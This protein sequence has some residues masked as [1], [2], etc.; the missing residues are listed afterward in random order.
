MVRRPRPRSET[1]VP[2][3]EK[4]LVNAGAIEQLGTPADLYF[5]PRTLFVADFLGESNLLSATVSEVSGQELGITLTDGR[6]ARRAVG[7]GSAFRPGQGVRIMVRPQNLTVRPASGQP[8]PLAGRLTRWPP[9][10]PCGWTSAPNRE[11][12]RTPTERNADS[13]TGLP[14]AGVQDRAV[15]GRDRG[16]FVREEHAVLHVPAA[17]VRSEKFRRWPRERPHCRSH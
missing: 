11:D 3:A 16:L 9:S 6:I 5:R 15:A 7:N 12:N 17:R 10:H 1:A 4:P 2:E 8:G 13:R 14:S